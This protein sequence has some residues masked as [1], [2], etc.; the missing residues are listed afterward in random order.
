MG[1]DM[2]AIAAAIETLAA[3]Y[4]DEMTGYC[5]LYVGGENVCNTWRQMGW[6]KDNMNT[7]LSDDIDPI[8]VGI[9]DGA[10]SCT[11]V[12]GQYNW[13]YEGVKIL[14]DYL[15]N[16]VTPPEFVE[17]LTYAVDAEK[18]EELYPQV[19]VEQ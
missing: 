18:A 10:A 16:G 3:K 4:K 2:T 1:A 14:V 17:T 9:K 15:A 6:N 5:M 8:I 13:G 11:V 7:V 19:K 12:Q